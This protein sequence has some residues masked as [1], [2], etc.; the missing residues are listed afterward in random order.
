MVTF[1][2]YS[3]PHPYP[4][5][6]QGVWWLINDSKKAS[7]ELITDGYPELCFLVKGGAKITIGKTEYTLPKNYI[8]GN[9]DRYIRLDFE[10]NTIIISIKLMPWALPSFF[11]EEAHVFTNTIDAL[12]NYHMVPKLL[13]SEMGDVNTNIHSCIEKTIFPYLGELISSE[14]QA[15]PVLSDNILH[16]FKNIQ[17]LSI[18]N[19]GFPNVG[20]RYLQKM[21]RKYIGL[22]PLKYQRLLKIKKAS[23]IL[24]KEKYET[25]SS[26]ASA[27]G[28]FDLSHFNKDFQRFT[29]TSPKEFA[30]NRANSSVLMNN[31]YV[32]QYEYS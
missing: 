8:V 31:T 14:K 5:L 12:E 19:K 7:L 26:L 10:P 6:I 25:I 4:K 15:A 21:Y 18:D 24:S 20:K 1:Y 2:R 3:K 11:N 16:L 23:L 13:L 30:E 22:S 28:Y 32:K 9:I 29:N 27:L 17:T